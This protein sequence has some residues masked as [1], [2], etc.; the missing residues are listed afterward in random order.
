[1]I[2]LQ[3]T[4][5]EELSH[6]KDEEYAAFQQKLI[7]VTDTGHF[8]GLRTPV[9]RDAAKKYFNDERKEAFLLELPHRYFDEDQLHAF[10]I[11]LEK[12]FGECIRLVEGFLPYIDNWATCDQLS[13]KVFAKESEKLLPYIKKWLDSDRTYTV[14]FAVGMLMAHFLDK[15]FSPEYPQLVADISSDEYYINMMRAW[16]FATALAK[17]Y[18]DIIGY[19]EDNK[20]DK[21]THNKTIQKAVESRRISPDQ[22]GYL[23]T[24]RIK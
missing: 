1:M 5:I 15:R 8:I 17:Q 23:R 20:L 18:D 4:F 21:W 19:I 2:L 6:L 14:R 24:L 12:D 7:P 9:L 11:S 16:Y 22:K 10:I 13:P 3:T